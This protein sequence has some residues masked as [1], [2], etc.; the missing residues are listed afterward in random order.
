MIKIER[1][2]LVAEMEAKK[3]A[4]EVVKAKLDDL[5][6]GTRPE[7]I[8]RAQ[9]EITRLQECEAY[10]KSDLTRNL[11][12]HQRGV[13]STESLEQAKVAYS[14]C[15]NDLQSAMERLKI[16]REGATKTQRAILEAQVKEA[17]AQY[18]ISREKVRECEVKAPFSGIVT[19]VF[20]RKGDL[21]RE[22]REDVVIMEIID[23]SSIVVR[24]HVPEQY[25]SLMKKNGNVS[26]AVDSM[27]KK[28]LAAKIVRVYPEIDDATHTLTLEASLNAPNISPGM[29]ARV[30]LPVYSVEN[31]LVIPDTALLPEKNGKYHVFIFKAGKALKRSV[32]KGLES[33][34]FV[35]VKKGLSAEDVVITAGNDKLKDGA[36]VKVPKKAEVNTAGK[37]GKLKK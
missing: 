31:A 33:G 30:K 11:K 7:E 24:F 25:A 16:L 23:P 5:N 6:A 9:H 4:L 19:K 21:V 37:N 29:F 3:A 32:N 22:G 28:F 14:K 12:L 36:P 26:I 10:A 17:E 20:V 27:N 1:P 2:L 34:S 18:N 13:V 8:L 35:Q 15:S